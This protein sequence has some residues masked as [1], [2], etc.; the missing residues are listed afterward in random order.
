MKEDLE[1]KTRV[2]DVNRRLFEKKLVIQTWGN[3][4]ALTKKEKRIFIKP[5]GV[6]FEKLKPKLICEIDFNGNYSGNLRPS[7][8]TPIHIEIYKAFS[9]IGGIVHTHSHYATVFAQSGISIPCLGTTHA[10]CFRGD[11]PVIP[12][13]NK[14]EIENDYEKNIGEKIVSYFKR[15]NLDE[16]DM[17]AALLAYHGA[18]AWGKNIEEALEN[19]FILE[20]ISKMAYETIILTSLKNVKNKISPYLIE[21]HFKRKKGENKYYGQI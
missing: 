8:D 14:E 16:L 19:A 13:L 7:V 3:A 20:E 4:S 12:Q 5:S 9:K 18:F 6:K 17:P 1:L 21:K 2:A 15:N 10:D 11:I